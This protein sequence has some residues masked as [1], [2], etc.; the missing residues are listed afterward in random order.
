MEF[1]IHRWSVVN[2]W[3]LSRTFS[4]KTHLNCLVR[5]DVLT[6]RR[7]IQ[8]RWALVEVKNIYPKFQLSIDALCSLSY[9]VVLIRYERHKYKLRLKFEMNIISNSVCEK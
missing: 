1:C 8:H 7:L 4:V 6:V 3:P 2:N 9:Y 5:V